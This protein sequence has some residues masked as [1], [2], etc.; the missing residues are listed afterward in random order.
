MK[1]QLK[2]IGIALA[3]LVCAAALVIGVYLWISR[4][5]SFSSMFPIAAQ[6]ISFCHVTLYTLSEEDMEDQTGTL[7]QEQTEELLRRLSTE[8]YRLDAPS[9]FFSG[10]KVRVTISP[11]A[12]LH[13][14][15]EDGSLGELTLAGDHI[16]VIPPTSSS[17]SRLY[18]PEGGASFQEEI[19]G[20]LQSCLSPTS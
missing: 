16:R 8:E 20:Y 17:R 13:F 1:G 14:S 6:D 5:V 9:L 15:Q 2:Q 7:T 10:N 11:Y 4:P 3:I 19:V 12:I 18:T